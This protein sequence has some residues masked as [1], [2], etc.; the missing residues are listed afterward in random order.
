MYLREYTI[1]E[2]VNMGGGVQMYEENQ[3]LSCTQAITYRRAAQMQ[4]QMIRKMI[5]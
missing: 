1:D 3:K 5:I 4:G 2:M